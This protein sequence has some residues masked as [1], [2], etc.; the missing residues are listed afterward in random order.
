MHQVRLLAPSSTELL[1]SKPKL[2]TQLSDRRLPDARKC[3]VRPDYPSRSART[4][5]SAAVVRPRPLIIAF[6]ESIRAVHLLE[7]APMSPTGEL[8]Q[9]ESTL[10]GVLEMLDRVLAYAAAGQ[11]AD[12]AFGRYLMDALGGGAGELG[13]GGF[14]SSLEVRTPRHSMPAYNLIECPHFVGHVGDVL[15]GKPCAGTGRG[16]CTASTGNGNVVAA[17]YKSLQSCICST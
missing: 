9:L 7:N 12:A 15:L 8:A 2:P 16:I 10:K 3:R 13:K 6:Y 5:P 14:A 4:M 1:K 11:P 17:L